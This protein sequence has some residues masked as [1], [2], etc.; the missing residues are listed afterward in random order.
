MDR[1]TTLHTEQSSL[2]TCIQRVD[3]GVSVQAGCWLVYQLYERPLYI[4]CGNEKILITLFPVYQDYR[5]MYL[6]ID[7]PVIPMVT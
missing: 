5:N 3:P 2:S 4:F 6:T 1:T 7:N